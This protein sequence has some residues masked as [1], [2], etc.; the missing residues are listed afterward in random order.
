MGYGWKGPSTSCEL[1][2]PLWPGRGLNRRVLTLAQTSGSSSTGM[3]GWG[4]GH[5]GSWGSHSYVL[6]AAPG[7]QERVP[8]SKFH[9]LSC[10]FSF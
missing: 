7:W 6:P 5:G 2:A 4:T 3:E 1:S 8:A 9:I 10:Q